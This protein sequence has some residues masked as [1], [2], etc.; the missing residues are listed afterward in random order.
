M[1]LLSF[2]TK[3][4]IFL[5]LA[6]V[7]PFSWRPSINIAIKLADMQII[8]LEILAILELFLS[9]VTPALTDSLKRSESPSS[10]ALT[11]VNVQQELGSKLSS[12]A[13]LYF[14]NGIEFAN[15]TQR[16]SDHTEGNITFVVEAGTT[17]DV[18]AAVDQLS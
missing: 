15:L 5:Q 6:K 4:F 13:S 10:R 14:P 12:N 1:I 8:Y 16:W 3:F 7:P 9:L 17:E 2:L 18:A 11:P